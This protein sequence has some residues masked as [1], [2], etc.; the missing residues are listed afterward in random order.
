MS[1]YLNLIGSYLIKVDNLNNIKGGNLANTQ[2]VY[3][4]SCQLAAV[5]KTNTPVWSTLGS[6]SLNRQQLAGAGTN[7]AA[8]AFGGRCGSPAITVACTESYGAGLTTATKT[9]TIS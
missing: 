1:N 6:L 8:L 4:D 7:T 2:L 9:L 3:S 5:F